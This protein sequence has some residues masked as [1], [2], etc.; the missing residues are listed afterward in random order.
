MVLV[1]FSPPHRP[2][3]CNATRR[4]TLFPSKADREAILVTYLAACHA[5]L[6]GRGWAVL[7][8][9]Y[10]MD[11]VVCVGVTFHGTARDGGGG[12]VPHE[13]DRR[14]MMHRVPETGEE[15]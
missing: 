6:R 8:V 2:S 4:R 1:S 5:E 15:G 3:F 7:D 11:R 9:D 14:R 12:M 13:H 10:G